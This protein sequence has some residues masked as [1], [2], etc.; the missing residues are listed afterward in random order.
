MDIVQLTCSVLN[1]NVSYVL[2]AGVPWFRGKDIAIALGYSD[3]KRAIQLHVSDEDKTKLEELR[4]DNLSLISSSNL[5]LN[6]C[7]SIFINESGPYTLIIQSHKPEA[8]TFKHWITAEV[9]PSIRKHGTFSLTPQPIYPQIHLVNEYDLHVKVV[10]F[11]RRFR[12]DAVIVPGLGELQTTSALR[13]ESYR[14]GYIGGQPDLLILNRHRC[15]S[16]LALELKT[17]KGNGKLSENQSKYLFQ[18]E[19]SG[20]KVLVSNDYD[21]ILVELIDYFSGIRY[22]CPHC[23]GKTIHFKTLPALNIHLQKFHRLN[24]SV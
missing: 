8:K 17:P 19:Q 7:S 3:S 9:L 4:G 2:V 23:F 22:A 6:Q 20:F 5:T 11:I 13:C 14:K 10:G 1:C 12:P 18:L 21:Q 15:Y 24:P 16:G